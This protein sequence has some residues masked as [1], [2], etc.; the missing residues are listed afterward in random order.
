MSL[1]TVWRMVPMLIGESDQDLGGTDGKDTE[2]FQDPRLISEN[3]DHTPPATYL[4]ISV[5]ILKQ[6]KIALHLLDLK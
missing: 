2:A 4:F 3:T 1:E 5:S 6:I